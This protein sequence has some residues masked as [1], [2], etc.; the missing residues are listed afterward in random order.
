MEKKDRI[1]MDKQW[2]KYG[3]KGKTAPKDF[4]TD[5]GMYEAATRIHEDLLNLEQPTCKT[6]NRCWP[7]LPMHTRHKCSDCAKDKSDSR[8]FSRENV[9]DPSPMPEGL[10]LDVSPVEEMLFARGIGFVSMYRLLYG[11]TD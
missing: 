11:A 8:R 3:Y 9:I 5:G 10:P 2:A 4:Q 1:Q 6:C 7:G